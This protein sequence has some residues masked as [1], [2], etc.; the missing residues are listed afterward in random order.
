MTA[1]LLRILIMAVIFG[2]IALGVRRIWRDWQKQFKAEETEVHQRDL[3]ER[4]R[5][6]V[7]TLKRDADG[8]FR[9]PE[10]DNRR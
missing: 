9:P 4:K 1:I 3:E 8:T 10:N 6:D 5:P 2:A 7:I